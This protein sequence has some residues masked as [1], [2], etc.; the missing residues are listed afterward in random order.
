MLRLRFNQV[1]FGLMTL[2][3][4]SAFVA[5]QH[6]T[7]ASRV[8]FEGLFIPVS[9]PAFT[10]ANWLRRRIS[11]DPPDDTRSAQT[12]IQENLQLRQQVTQ[13]QMQVERL[14]GLAGER[15]NLG[16]LKELCDRVPVGGTDSG[17]REGLI[18][19]GMNGAIQK[20]QPV[21]YA[22]GLA[23]KI[24]RAGLGAAHVLL[25]TDAGFN[26]TGR[27]IRFVKS[28][29]GIEARA[30]STAPVIVQG[31]GGGQMTVTK[32][33]YADAVSEGIKPDDWIILADNDWPAAVQGIR[34]GRIASIGHWK[35]QPLFA[36]I[37][38]EPQASL[39]R[40]AD[41]W[42]MTRQP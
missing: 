36:E 35:R 20:E 1:F 42:V 31:A 6:L 28:A 10:M 21:V 24:D 12:L 7:D 16:D 17:S 18:L 4:I 13:L 32:L 34:I 11:P 5:P 40:L 19:S 9:R 3:F 39:L 41:V 38:L 30:I 37:R 29:G 15:R 27:I 26:I 2:S 25:I 23:G 33:S 8:Q 14:Q 22:G